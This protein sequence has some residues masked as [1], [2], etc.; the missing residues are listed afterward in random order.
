MKSDINSMAIAASLLLIGKSLTRNATPVDTSTP[1]TS[2]SI[3]FTISGPG[4]S[5]VIIPE[6]EVAIVPGETVLDVTIR[7]LEEAD[8]PFEVAGIG[9][10]AYILS[11]NGISQYQYGP[12]SKWL[13]NIDGE[14]PSLGPA[15]YTLLDD[16]RLEWI[17]T[18]DGGQDIGA[19][20]ISYQRLNNNTLARK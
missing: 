10:A 8:L 2:D 14:Y 17:Y 16:S 19:P 4:N 11:I 3:I 13:Y 20:N 9:D 6:A 15:E 5:N 18:V 12:Q 1:E 7:I